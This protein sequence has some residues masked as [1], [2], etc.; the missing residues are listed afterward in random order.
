MTSTRTTTEA[1]DA[2]ALIRKWR[3]SPRRDEQVAAE[4]AAQITSGRLHPWRQFPPRAALAEEHGVS[5]GTIKHAKR[6]LG[7]HGLLTLEDGRYYVP[8][9]ERT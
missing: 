7:D 6:L 4:L 3:A 9:A 8:W 5:V 1:A 2:G